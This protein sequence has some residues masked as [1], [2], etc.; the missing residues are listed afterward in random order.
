MNKK[1]C[2]VVAMLLICTSALLIPPEELNAGAISRETIIF[3]FDSYN[4]T[5]AWEIHYPW[6]GA[7]TTISCDVELL[8]G[9]TCSWSPE[10]YLEFS[11]GTITKVELRVYGNHNGSQYDIILRPVYGGSS[12]GNDHRFNT[13]WCPTYSPWFDITEDNNAP[14]TW[15]WTDVVNLDCDVEAECK[16][17]APFTLF[18]W[19]VQ[20]CVTYYII[21]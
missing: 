1:I 4:Q 11:S 12:D 7:S 13:V 9:N 19:K 17:D 20:I 2:S 14:E 6:G 21:C 5:E 3:D 8:D 16:H 15:T 10:C 18:Y